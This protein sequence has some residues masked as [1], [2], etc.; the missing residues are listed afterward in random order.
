MKKE[1]LTKEEEV[2]LKLNKNKII[3]GIPKETSFQEDRICLSP[4]SVGVL[5]S[6]NIT[7]FI[8]EG[9]GL[10]ANFS[11][12][13]YSENGAV[14]V[15]SSDVYKKSNLILKVEPPTIEEV[16]LMK[17][18]QIL[19]S[20][21][22]IKAINKNYLQ[23]LLDKKITAIAFEYMEDEVGEISI[24]RAM[25]EIAGNTSILIASEY[26]SNVN[27]G[28]GLMLGGISGVPSAEIVVLG[29]GTVGEFASR[30]AIG[31]GAS[32]KVFDNHLYKLRR[33]KNNLNSNIYT[34]TL[35][36][37]LLS[38]CLRR[39]D[40]VIGALRGDFGRTPCVVFEDMIK[41]MKERSVIIDVSIDQGGCFE[42]SRLTTHSNPVFINNEVIHYCV[43]NITSRVART[44]SNALSNIL[45]PVV[46]NIL[47]FNNFES[48]LKEFKG[49]KKGVY[50]YNGML[51]NKNVSDWYDIDCY[52][53]N[54]LLD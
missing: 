12:S 6:D 54:S 16:K 44:A 4:E 51:S 10:G 21:L 22:Q 32:V 13:D 40:V 2:V 46:L 34:S 37:K 48:C 25:S 23:K 20:A 50:I 45:L 28:K 36:P 31:L 9:A 35:Q 43:P 7:V 17:E 19:I 47:K 5:T 38:K 11:D 1:K 8:E 29:A 24:V 15:S 3:I 42:T 52:D 39:A 27:E 30:A 49:L 33:L 53:I 41:Q 26:L 14:I 18:N